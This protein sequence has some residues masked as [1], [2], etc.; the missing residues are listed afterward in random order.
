MKSNLRIKL[1]SAWFSID[2]HS[3]SE[4]GIDSINEIEMVI[5]EFE[6]S[7][8]FNIF[9]NCHDHLRPEGVLKINHGLEIIRPLRG[10][11]SPIE[12]FQI[13]REEWSRPDLTYD[14]LCRILKLSGFLLT[15]VKNDRIIA[16]KESERLR[17][18]LPEVNI[19]IPAYKSNFFY[20]ALLSAAGQSY[21]NTRV[22]VA[23]EGVDRNIEQIVSDFQIKFP[24]ARITYIKHTSPKGEI[25]N[26][27]FCRKVASGKYL[28]YLNDDD[29]LDPNCV[30]LFVRFLE[31]FEDSVTLISSRRN[32]V[33]S[34]NNEYEVAPELPFVPMFHSNVYVFGKEVIEYLLNNNFNQLGEPS[35]VM[36]RLKDTDEKLTR[37]EDPQYP[38][39][40]DMILNFKLLLKGNLIYLKDALSLFRVHSMQAS[41]ITD[42]GSLNAYKVW[43]N[44]ILLMKHRYNVFRDLGIY[45]LALGRARTMLNQGLE[46]FRDASA[47]SSL[48]EEIV[49][50]DSE[51]DTLRNVKP[52]QCSL[53]SFFTLVD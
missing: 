34:D 53:Q 27:E 33:D 52:Q 42:F 10:D 35:V 44:M 50:L 49:K 18:F 2:H 30:K 17:N 20:Y 8:L 40:F 19:T 32:V 45:R 24:K 4:F 5:D 16:T 37:I 39:S 43:A 3:L 9:Q 38:C 1:N 22:I 13:M 11:E 26:F 31:A 21:Q 41:K 28:K 47:K 7:T 12:K 51:L 29:I 15:T 14:Y 25:E 48:L 6:K 23:D 46:K 36:F